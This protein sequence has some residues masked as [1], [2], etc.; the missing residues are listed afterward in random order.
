MRRIAFGAAAV[1]V[2]VIIA[3]CGGGE[4]AEPG[5][6]SAEIT[7]SA[8]DSLLAS[9]YMADA[10]PAGTS[11]WCACGAQVC[12]V[13][14]GSLGY[15]DYVLA[16]SDPDSLYTRTEGAEGFAQTIGFYAD[17]GLDQ[18]ADTIT[19]SD[20]QPN[21]NIALNVEAGTYPSTS[22]ADTLDEATSDTLMAR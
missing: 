10:D 17:G 19:L 15:G 11:Q 22:E 20:E 5:T 16:I 3:G 8:Q 2:G 7:C 12:S 9:V 4:E 6:I 18:V 1:V 13:E 14:F 21:A